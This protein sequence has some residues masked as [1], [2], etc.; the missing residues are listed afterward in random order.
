MF[1][2]EKRKFVFYF[3]IRV[4]FLQSHLSF[5][6]N[7]G[8]FSVNGTALYKR[9]TPDSGTKLDSP[10]PK[11]WT[12][13]FAHVNGKHWLSWSIYF[14]TEFSGN[15]VC[16]KQPGRSLFSRSASPFLVASPLPTQITCVTPP[17]KQN[18]QFC[19]RGE[20]SC[21]YATTSPGYQQAVCSVCSGRS[22]AYSFQGFEQVSE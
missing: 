21:T 6:F 19:L 22:A 11:P 10:E 13:R 3:F 1:H 16:C 20:G 7:C 15:F 5:Q 18:P 8:R 4:L 17:F 12:D 9:Q 2:R 14:Q